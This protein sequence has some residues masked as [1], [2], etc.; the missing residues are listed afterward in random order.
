MGIARE[1]AYAAL[2]TRL[3]T[4]TG[5]Q[6]FSRRL[7]AL[8]DLSKKHQPAVMMVPTTC[9]PTVDSQGEPTVWRLAADVY[10][11]TPPDQ[12]TNGGEYTLLGLIDQVDAALDRTTTEGPMHFRDQAE[13]TLAGAV[14]KA[15]VS[16]PIEI[17]AG[18]ESEQGV[19][20]IPV[21]ML[22]VG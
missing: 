9:T 5:V 4:L 1:A 3:Q 22:M 12:T 16:G 11:V 8:D 19:A 14:L 15:Y 17:D 2:Y 7:L 6:K 21:E 10:I 20:R 18:T 13:T